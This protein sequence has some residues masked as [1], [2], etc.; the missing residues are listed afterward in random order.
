MGEEVDRTPVTYLKAEVVS[1]GALAVQVAPWGGAEAA[2]W[3]PRPAEHL[4]AAAACQLEN[5]EKYLG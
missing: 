5:L 2:A 3:A 4:S 1:A